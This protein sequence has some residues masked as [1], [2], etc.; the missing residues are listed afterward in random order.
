MKTTALLLAVLLLA[1][2]PAAA[3][4]RPGDLQPEAKGERAAACREE[5]SRRLD[6]QRLRAGS[7][8]GF[9]DLGNGTE[10]RIGGR[11]RVE[12]EGRR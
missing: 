10:V 5:A 6:D 12:A 3:E 7:Q 8:P 1:A 2:G 11:A 9:I 4:C